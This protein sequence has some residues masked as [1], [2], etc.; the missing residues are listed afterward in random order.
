MKSQHIPSAPGFDYV[1]ILLAL[2]HLHILGVTHN[3]AVGAGSWQLSGAALCTPLWQDTGWTHHRIFKAFVEKPSSHPHP[4][5]AGT[6]LISLWER[7]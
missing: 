4:G 6:V 2:H 5:Q 1:H 3:K 7:L